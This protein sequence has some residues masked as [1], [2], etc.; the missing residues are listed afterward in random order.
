MTLADLRTS[1]PEWSIWRSDAGAYYASRHL[2]A[3]Q[4]REG[5]TATL[6]ADEL[7]QLAD[8]LANCDTSTAGAELRGAVA[9]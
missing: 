2:V 7:G 8:L 1:H 4:L 3:S 6:A 5:M 9:S